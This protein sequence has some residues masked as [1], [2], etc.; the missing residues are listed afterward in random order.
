MTLRT[1]LFIATLAGALTLSTVSYGQAPDDPRKAQADAL[2]QEGVLRLHA[3]DHEAEALDRFRRAATFTP[4]PA[5]RVSIGQEEQLL[6]EPLEAIRHYREAL[7]N[8][9]LNPTYTGSCRI[10]ASRDW[11]NERKRAMRWHGGHEIRW[12]SCGGVGVGGW[13][14]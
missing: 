11:R 13:L 7:K 10:N 6:G 3:Q 14:R 4:S 5:A 12:H 9:L 1:P 8:P 2:F